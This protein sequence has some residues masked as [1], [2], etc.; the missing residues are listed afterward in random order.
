MKVASAKFSG[1]SALVLLAALAAPA[2]AV[3]LRSPQVAFNTTPLQNYFTTL[4]QGINVATDQW[5]IQCWSTTISRNSTLT[6]MLD[7]GVL[8]PNNAIGIYNCAD[9][10]PSIKVVFPGSASPGWFA[11]VSFNA[12]GVAGN[13]RV[14]LFDDT[15]AF[16]SSTLYTGVNSTNFGF[17]L[18]NTNGPYYSQDARN[19]GGEPHALVYPGTGSSAGQWWLCFEDSPWLPTA[20]DFINPVIFMESVNPPVP[21]EESTWG[22]VKSLF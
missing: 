7:G 13:V 2:L 20:S 4:G 22:G 21:V 16:V 15:A 8:A 14:N 19:P 18:I 9:A 12:G 10:V 17:A 6:M 5:D 11:V 1:V 3:G